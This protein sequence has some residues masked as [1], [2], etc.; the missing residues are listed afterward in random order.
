MDNRGLNGNE[1][2]E[3]KARGTSVPQCLGFNCQSNDREPNPLSFSKDLSPP[4]TTGLNGAMWDSHKSVMEA[5]SIQI[6]QK[7]TVKQSTE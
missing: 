7:D 6:K 4:G 3:G 5:I 1:W 2:E